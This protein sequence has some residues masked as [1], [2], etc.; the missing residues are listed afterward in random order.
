MCNSVRN[1]LVRKGE[2]EMEYELSTSKKGK[3]KYWPVD[4][5][6]GLDEDRVALVHVGEL[7]SLVEHD[8]AV[9]LRREGVRPAAQ[10]ADAHDDDL[11]LIR[12]DRRRLVDLDGLAA[13]GHSANG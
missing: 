9:A 2:A 13:V 11:C 1:N 7:S 12:L 3:K 5:L 6:V 10:F 8:G 4:G